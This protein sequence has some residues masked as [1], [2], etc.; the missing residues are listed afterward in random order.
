[1]TKM[2]IVLIVLCLL[3]AANLVSFFLM[4]HDKRCAQRG[5]RRVPESKLFFV[6]ACF[7]G[8]AECLACTLCAIKQSIGIS[9][10]SSR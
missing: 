10:S 6:A 9:E 8:L 5:L 1:M 2:T 4:R 3:T 7:G